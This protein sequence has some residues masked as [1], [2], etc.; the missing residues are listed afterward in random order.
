MVW[1]ILTCWEKYLAHIILHVYNL[2]DPHN[3]RSRAPHTHAR[4]NIE[5][6][7]LFIGV[8]PNKFSHQFVSSSYKQHTNLLHCDAFICITLNQPR[9]WHLVLQHTMEHACRMCVQLH[10]GKHEQQYPAT[11]RWVENCIAPLLLSA[12]ADC[13]ISS[14]KQLQLQLVSCW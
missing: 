1:T 10:I 12:E 4:I 9:V 13:I 7:V 11:T 2:F 5:D 6:I 3:Q 8:G 14:F